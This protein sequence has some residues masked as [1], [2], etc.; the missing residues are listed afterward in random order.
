MTCVIAFIDKDKN[1]VIAGDKAA[2]DSV[3]TFSVKAPKVFSNG[4]FLVGYEGSFRMG[5]V[6]QYNW[7]PPEKPEDKTTDEFMHTDVIGSILA[8]FKEYLWQLEED[9]DGDLGPVGGLFILVFE[10]RVFELQGDMSILEPSSEVS[11]IGSGSPKALVAFKIY[12]EYE[13]DTHKLLTKVF[14]EVSSTVKSVTKEFD[15][16]LKPCDS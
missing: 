15:Y 16:I 5:Q 2:S 9:E 10:G 1:A 8:C 4:D 12:S 3:E 7:C 14:E 6:L 13:K 11:S